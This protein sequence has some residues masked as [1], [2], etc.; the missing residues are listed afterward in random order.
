MLTIR[1]PA[2]K[3]LKTKFRVNNM[4]NNRLQEDEPSMLESA[5]DHHWHELRKFGETTF[6]GDDGDLTIV[7][8]TSTDFDLCINKLMEQALK[9]FYGV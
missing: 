5:T 7:D 6:H 4:E 2:Y 3:L 1:S 9:D 8:N